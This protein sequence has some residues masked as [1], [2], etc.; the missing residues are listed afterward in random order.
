MRGLTLAVLFVVISLT[1]AGAEAPWAGVY[2]GDWASDA[3]GVRGGFR[4][5]L[6]AAGEGKWLGEV[7]FTIA[8]M[9]FKTT[10]KSLKIEGTKIE[11]SYEYELGDGAGRLMSTIT[12]GLEGAKVEGRYQ[13]KSVPDGGVVDEGVWKA[14]RR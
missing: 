4:M 5:T 14:A 11:M 6:K 9:E 7:T 12:G 10:V 2:Q 3:S 1:A 13:A 8:E